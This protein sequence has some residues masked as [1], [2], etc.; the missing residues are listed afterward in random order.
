MLFSS[1]LAKVC[2]DPGFLYTGS[3]L[4]SFRVLAFKSRRAFAK[5]MNTKYIG[6]N[7]RLDPL[8]GF[9]FRR[10]L[11]SDRCMGPEDESD[12]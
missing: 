9:F 1:K 6:V 3:N 8:P 7:C 10:G 2:P 12:P 4:H 11:D 5:K